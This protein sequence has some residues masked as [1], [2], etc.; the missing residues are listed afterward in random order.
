M[1]PKIT[2]YKQTYDM[3][4]H[5]QNAEYGLL[6]SNREIELIIWR[7]CHADDIVLDSVEHARSKARSDAEREYSVAVDRKDE[8]E[9]N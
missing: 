5:V 8:E 3:E 1:T 9:D 7:C 4:L 6:L 2:A